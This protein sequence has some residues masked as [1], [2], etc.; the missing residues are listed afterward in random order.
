MKFSKEVL[1]G[2]TPFLVLHSLHRLEEAY[3]YELMKAIREHS[4]AIFDFPD[5]TL[6]PVL[7]RLEEKGLV[8]SEVK[9]TPNKKDRR[10]YSLTSKGE[11][12]LH[13]SQKEFRVY[14]QGL[15][16]FISPCHG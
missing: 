8:R 1:K 2:V 10:Y 4:E 12:E 16:H 11:K 3:G 13:A 7:Y 14:L 6:Y 15:N 5:S 9:E